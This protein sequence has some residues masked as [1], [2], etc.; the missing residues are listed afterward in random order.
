MNDLIEIKSTGSG[1]VIKMDPDGAIEDEIRE[2]C[3]K[4]AS[5]R[6]FFGASY[7]VLKIEGRK[8][9]EEEVK[10]VVDSIELNSSLKIACIKTDDKVLGKEF[11][12]L[13]KG[14][15]ESFIDGYAKMIFKV[16]EDDKVRSDTSM[17]VLG[18]VPESASLK[19]P[20]SIIVF[21]NLKGYAEAG[22]PDRDNCFIAAESISSDMI[23]IG[24][25]ICDI[26]EKPKFSLRKKNRGTVV[27][28]RKDKFIMNDFGN[29]NLY[30]HLM[31]KK[32]D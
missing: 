23:S 25:H 19:C 31:K 13:L 6:K 28:F 2:I 18:D 17:I 26:P 22:S 32:D 7:I 20:G 24:G 11:F 30:K 8:L 10:A 21:G 14:D 5:S 3:V 9:D 4:F 1:M 29:I 27:I 12:N 15:T 16:N